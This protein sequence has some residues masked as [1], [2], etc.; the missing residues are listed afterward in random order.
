MPCRTKVGWCE[1][2]GVQCSL[3]SNCFGL[4]TGENFSITNIGSAVTSRQGSTGG[5]SEMR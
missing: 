1:C 5:G 4:C 3:D 2:S